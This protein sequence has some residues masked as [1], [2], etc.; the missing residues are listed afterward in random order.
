[1]EGE[2][3]GR[4]EKEEGGGEGGGEEVCGFYSLFLSLSCRPI[5]SPRARDRKARR[6]AGRPQLLG[7]ARRGVG[8]KEC[9]PTRVLFPLSYPHLFFPG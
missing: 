2:W 8:G 5:A 7:T 3:E 9:A 6:A 4:E 1:M